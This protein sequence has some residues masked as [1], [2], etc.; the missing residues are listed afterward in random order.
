MH[1]SLQT[2]RANFIA[3]Y[4]RKAYAE[5]VRDFTHGVSGQ[6]TATRLGVSRERIRQWR[7]LFGTT[8]TIWTP[9]PKDFIS[10]SSP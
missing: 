4:G 7:G 6:I 9:H 2:V 8:V 1:K 10:G 5:L 3:R